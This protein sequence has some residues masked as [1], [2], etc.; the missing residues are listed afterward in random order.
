MGEPPP[1]AVVIAPSD[2]EWPRRAALEAMRLAAALGANL[3]RTE[4]VGSTSVPGL[5][6]KPVVDLMPIVASLDDLDWQRAKVETLGYKW[7][8]EFGIAGRRFCTMTR[9]GERVGHLHFFQQGSA[10]IPKHTVFRD[11][12][13]AHPDAARAYEIEKRRAAAIHP[14]DSLAYNRE[15][16]DW[17]AAELAKA[18]AWAGI[19]DNAHA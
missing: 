12:L 6:A 1:H 5:A 11:Y 14:H 13:R 19:W 4:H 16:A 3:L 17:V 18:K 2:P 9:N 10:E 7:F 8:G 15:K